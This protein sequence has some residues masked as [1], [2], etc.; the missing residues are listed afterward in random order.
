MSSKDAKAGAQVV[1]EALEKHGVRYVF[2]IP[3]AKI[4]KV[5]NPK[6]R[7]SRGTKLRLIV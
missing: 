4:D 3:G 2:G 5:F 1:V 7:R 6:F